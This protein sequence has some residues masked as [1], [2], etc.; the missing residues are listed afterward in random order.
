APRPT[1]TQGDK[2]NTSCA[3]RVPLRFVCEAALIGPSLLPT[4]VI[5][6]DVLVE[7]DRRIG[8]PTALAGSGGGRRLGLD[9]SRDHEYSGPGGAER[10][11][12]RRRVF[13]GGGAEDARGRA[14]GTRR[15]R[16]RIAGE[17]DQEPRPYYRDHATRHHAGQPGAGLG[18]GGGAGYGL[19][20][21]FCR[22]A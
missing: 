16:R 12:C 8:E 1:R 15:R 2:R 10:V 4:Y 5:L 13:D 14:C 7:E 18:G 21:R 20:C 6:K 17:G 22:L 9:R 11:F 19:R 3:C